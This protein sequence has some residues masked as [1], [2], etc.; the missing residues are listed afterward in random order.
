MGLHTRITSHTLSFLLCVKGLIRWCYVWN[1]KAYKLALTL[2]DFQGGIKPNNNNSTCAIWATW[3]NFTTTT[4]YHLKGW[5]PQQLT[6]YMWQ[7]SR[8]TPWY[9]PPWAH[10]TRVDA[11]I[12][13]VTPRVQNCLYG[14]APHVKRA[15]I[16]IASLLH[17]HPRFM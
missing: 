2:L 7:M 14:P 10:T 1:N 13:S 15:C 6:T 9:T 16:R 11:P 4:G 12:P 8:I 17:F 3:A 5:C